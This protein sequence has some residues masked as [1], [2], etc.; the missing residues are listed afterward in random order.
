MDAYAILRQQALEKRDRVI[1]AARDECRRVMREIEALRRAMDGKPASTDSEVRNRTFLEMIRAVIPRDRAFTSKDVAALLRRANP[2]DEY[3][4]TSVR[5]YL[6]QLHKEGTVVRIGS[7]SS[8]QTL[9]AAAGIEVV[10]CPRG[11]MAML[12]LATRLLRERG[13]MKSSELVAKMQDAGYRPNSDPC[14]VAGWLRRTAR[15]HPG[16]ICETQDGCWTLV[17]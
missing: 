1:Q 3:R 15:M 8:G 2:G 14:R 17:N 13:L 12:D 10:E 7:T 9:W 4:S 5:H 6:Q 16:R 11:A